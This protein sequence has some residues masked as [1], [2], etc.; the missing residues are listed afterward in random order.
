VSSRNAQRKHAKATQ[1][2]KILEQRRRLEP[3]SGGGELAREIR[4]AAAQPLHACL[5][6][7]S[8]FQSGVGMVFLSRKTGGGDVALSG[9]LVD[10]YCLGVKD[11]MF[12]ELNVGEMEELLDGAGA[13]APLTPVDP[14]YARKLLRA[15]A[16]YARSLGL[17]PHPDFETV[18]LLFGD[19][20]ADACDVEFQFGYEGRP[21]YVPGPTES[22]TQI[23]RRIDRLRRRLGDDGFDFS[24]PEDALDAPDQLDDGEMGYDADVDPDP[25]HWLALDEAERLRQAMDYHE[26]HDPLLAEP[27]IHAAI[28]VM[29][30]NQIATDDET[31]AREALE[32]L[33]SEGLSRHEA[34]HALGSVL[35]EM[36]VAIANGDDG[37]EAERFRADAYNGAIARITAEDWR[38]LAAED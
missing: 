1:R 35:T 10:A 6:Q 3:N 32:R 30:E 37:E 14:P 2:K 20:A 25:A 31:P 22:A 4:R 8:V 18:E 24:L 11:A 27:D 7:D 29:I 9:F 28:H 26:R 38:R 5:V 36:I 34:I 13:T 15:A 12:R 23:R 33:M 19:V 17:S 21:L 16:A